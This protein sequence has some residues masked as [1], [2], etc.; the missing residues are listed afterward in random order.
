MP[1][2][3]YRI[4]DGIIQSIVIVLIPS[5]HLNRLVEV[6]GLH[7]GGTGLV[8]LDLA[9]WILGNG[10]FEQGVPGGHQ[11]GLTQRSPEEAQDRGAEDDEHPRVNDGVDREEPQSY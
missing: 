10:R 6:C 4:I 2:K 3:S 11:G 9:C 8:Q 7:T 1:S 5:D